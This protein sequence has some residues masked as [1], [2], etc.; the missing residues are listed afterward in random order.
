MEPKIEKTD[1]SKWRLLDEAGRQTWHYLDDE[2]ANKEWPQDIATK[3]H[4]G[5][6]TVCAPHTSPGPFLC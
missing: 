5:L 3:Y 1:Y 6:P 4:L 2:K